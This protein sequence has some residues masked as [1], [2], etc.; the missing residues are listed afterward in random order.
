MVC[1]NHSCSGMRWLRAWSSH[2][3]RMSG[4]TKNVMWVESRWDCERLAAAAEVRAAGWSGVE[5]EA[6][7]M[8]EW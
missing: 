8:R 3:S 1:W 4:S 6:W 2:A 5:A 7:L